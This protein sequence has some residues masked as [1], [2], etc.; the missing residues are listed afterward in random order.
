MKGDVAA[1]LAEFRSQYDTGAD[2]AAVLTDLA[3]FNHLVTRLRFVPSALEDASLSEDER[4]RGAAFSEQLSV[5]VLSRTWQMLLK[6]IPEVQSS[7]RPVSA[8][9]M[10]MIRIA[11]AADLPTLDEALKS[12][13][14]GAQATASP[15]PS[16]SSSPAGSAGRGNGE[17][18]SAVSTASFAPVGNGAQTM[19]L[20]EAS[21]APATVTPPQPMPDAQPAISIRSLADIAALAE[22]HRDMAFKILLKKYIRPVRFDAD[23]LDVSLTDDAPK[24]LLNDLATKLRSW[25]G[26]NFFVSLS[27]ETGGPTLAEMDSAQRENDFLDA[28]NDPAVAAILDR[29]PGAKIIDVRIPDAAQGSGEADED[30]TAEPMVEDDD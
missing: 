15:R 3:E 6:G 5:K 30:M 26:R 2:P 18:A 21:P 11:H 14:S 29:F 22:E 19:R 25:T 8:A 27:K 23:R 13:E 12:L 20:V 9:E 10:V 28:R 16:T 7:N 17:T 4:R 1:A 24:T